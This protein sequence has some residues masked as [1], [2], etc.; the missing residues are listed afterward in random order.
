MRSAR[1]SL[2]SH[3]LKER[4]VGDHSN[5]EEGMGKCL[6]EGMLLLPSGLMTK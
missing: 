2:L 5:E 4:L 3:Y 6:K 1:A